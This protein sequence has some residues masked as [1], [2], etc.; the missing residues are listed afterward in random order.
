MAGNSHTAK[1]ELAERLRTR[2]DEI[3]HTLLTRVY[4][5]SD[6]ATVKDPEY[7]LGLRLAVAAAFDYALTALE[8]EFPR[9]GTPH[10]LLTQA[11]MAARNGVRLET[12]LR[13][14]FA[15][16]TVLCDCLHREA[17]SIAADPRSLLRVQAELFDRL[18]PTVTD[19]YG[20]EIEAR[21]IGLR[22]SRRRLGECVNRLLAGE[23]ADAEQLNYDLDKWH[24]GVVARG[25][26]AEAT[27]HR[28][29][30][31]LDLRF[32]SVPCAEDIVWIWLGASEYPHPAH[33]CDRIA[34]RRH[35][36]AYFALGEPARNVDGWRLT[37]RQAVAAMPMAKRDTSGVIN[38]GDVALL[39]AV[40]RDDVLAESLRRAYL[41]PLETEHDGGHALR[42]TLSAFLAAGRN[43]SSAAAA[44]GVSRQTLKKR[45]CTAEERIGQ[46]LDRRSAEIQTALRLPGLQL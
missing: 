25:I 43:A 41:I 29:A 9:L 3:E 34:E 19:A 21:Q 6:P 46:P 33:L 38:Y 22:P 37:H 31:E 11:R 30:R 5:V 42:E 39:A 40:L 2:R 4:A 45:I 12:V 26:G 16:Y 15:G 35:A 1:L 44:L 8:G 14:Y 27:V 7:T 17:Q 28:V 32:L 23:L 20:A 13:R 10:Q 18:V 24:I 36:A